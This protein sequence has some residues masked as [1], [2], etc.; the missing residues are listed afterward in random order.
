MAY[1]TTRLCTGCG[2]VKDFWESGGKPPAQIC[3]DC[4]GKA[5]EAELQ[6][7]LAALAELPTEERLR[8]IEAWIYRHGKNHPQ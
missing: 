3:S 7:H 8:R 4:E 2:E 1:R 6:K 5:A